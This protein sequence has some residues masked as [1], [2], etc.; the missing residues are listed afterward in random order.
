MQRLPNKNQNRQQWLEK[1]T[2]RKERERERETYANSVRRPTKNRLYQTQTCHQHQP[3]HQ[4]SGTNINTWHSLSPFH[5]T[6]SPNSS[7]GTL[8]SSSSHSFSTN[9]TLFLPPTNEKNLSLWIT[10][11][12]Q[13][14]QMMKRGQKWHMDRKNNEHKCSNRYNQTI[15][16]KNN[17]MQQNTI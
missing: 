12:S 9:L 14:N 16:V 2:Q 1:R 5:F 4:P 7:S 13:Q 3:K 10:I 15:G 6:Y 8:S 11:Y 17:K